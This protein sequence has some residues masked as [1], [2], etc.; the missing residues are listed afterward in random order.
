M[1]FTFPKKGYNSE[2]NRVWIYKD[3]FFSA[4]MADQ[5]KYHSFLCM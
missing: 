4:C 5:D 3:G 1:I 2:R